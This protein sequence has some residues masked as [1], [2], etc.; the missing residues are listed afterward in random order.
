V[1]LLGQR[2]VA[3][4]VSEQFAKQ[5][6]DSLWGIIIVILFSH[7]VH[8]V[9]AILSSRSNSLRLIIILIITP[10]LPLP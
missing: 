9:L 10:S 6:S 4:K 3:E 5:A 7:H 2:D 1:L 8:P